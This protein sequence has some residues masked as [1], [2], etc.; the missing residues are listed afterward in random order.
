[1]EI[2]GYAAPSTEG[3]RTSSPRAGVRIGPIRDARR[4]SV[5]SLIGERTTLGSISLGMIEMQPPPA[6]VL[7]SV[8]KAELIASGFDII[9]DEKAAN[10]G[11]QVTKFLVTTPATALYWDINGA[12]ELELVAQGRDGRKHEGRY[13]SNCTDRTFVFPSA[14]LISGVVMA[15]LREI[16]AKLR[17]DSSLGDILA[18][19]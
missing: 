2:K 12:V 4:D 7:S 10:V 1:V 13:L 5:G 18:A 3:T 15:C 9:S 8:L 14:D 6:E 19:P 16:G 11:G 17:K